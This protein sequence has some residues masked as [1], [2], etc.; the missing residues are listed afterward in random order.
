MGRLQDD[1]WVS[2]LGNYSL[3]K[4]Q[5]ILKGQVLLLYEVFMNLPKLD[6]TH[7]LKPNSILIPVPL[8]TLICLACLYPPM[9]LSFL[10]LETITYSFLPSVEVG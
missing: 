7:G 6:V 3:E 2:V 8:I 4:V 9:D 10:K 1:T 5:L